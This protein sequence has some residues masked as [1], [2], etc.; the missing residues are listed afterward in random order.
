MRFLDREDAGRQL[1][2]RLVR[3]QR[4]DPLVLGLPRGGVL[5]AYEVAAALGAPLDVWVVRKVGA[6]DFPE[7]GVGAVAEG[8][9]VYLNQE[10]IR[11]VGASAA[12]IEDILQEES[13]EVARRV[14]L[15]R[16]ERPSPTV[17]GRTVILVD[18]GIATGGTV[19][20]AVQALRTAHPKQIV[21]AAPVAASQSL[22]EL[23][24]FVDDILC[25][26]ATPTLHAIG[27]WYEDF[28]QVSD[29]EVVRVLERARRTAHRADSNDGT[30][31]PSGPQELTISIG[32]A[33]L[34]GTLSGPCSPKGLVL[35]AHGSGSGRSSP[36]N[37]HVAS[38]LHGFGLATLLFDLLTR[39]EEAFDVQTAALRFDIDLLARRLIQV[40]DWAL[41]SPHTR[42]LPIGYFGASTG[43]A[44]ALVAAARRGDVIRAIVSRGG[45]PDLAGD[46]LQRVRA[47]TLLVVGGEDRQVIELNQRASAQMVAPRRLVVLPGASHLFEEPGALDAVARLAGEW[48]G[49]HLGR[50]RPEISTSS[51]EA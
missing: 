44:A 48:L 24:P 6:P 29:A 5:V 33:E 32:D 17:T 35:F 1:A 19:R 45:R 42:G 50:V 41:A 26:H 46:S 47:P 16:G 13:A 9:I 30:N 38:M 4:E 15:L 37:R 8:G 25:V 14:R 3:Y 10:L 34:S 49:E 51:G 36:R 40:T 27:A 21:L 28:G 43:A 39:E 7:L 11:E 22:E 12:D 18:D 23:A 20:A 2:Q 31:A